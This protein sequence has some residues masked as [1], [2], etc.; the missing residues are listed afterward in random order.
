M[1]ISFLGLLTITLL[2]LNL[3]GVISVS[4]WIVFL[5]IILGFSVTLIIGFAVVL[6]IVN[7]DRW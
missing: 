5:P 2:V 1:S 4:W 3:L 7:Y 6:G